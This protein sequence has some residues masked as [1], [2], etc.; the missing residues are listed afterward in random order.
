MMHAFLNESFSQSGIC[1]VNISSNWA[2]DLDLKDLNFTSRGYDPDAAYRQAK[3]ADRMLTQEWARR[4]GSGY[5][6][7]SCHPGDPCTKLSTALGYNLHA[8]KDCSRVVA[9]NILPLLE[10][11]EDLVSGDWY[12]VAQQRT[13][14]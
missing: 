2:G 5:T 12:E 10:Y 6:L 9:E 1:A 4:L 3:Q 13:C 7:V 14:Q 8:S 11:V